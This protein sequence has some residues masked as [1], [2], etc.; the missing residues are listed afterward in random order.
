MNKRIKLAT[1]FY[2]DDYKRFEEDENKAGIANFVF[3]RL[4]ERYLIPLENVPSEFKNGFSLMANACLLI[5]TYESFRQGW[6]DTSH[7]EDRSSERRIPFKSF[8]SREVGFSDFKYES[9]NFY[10]NVRCG[11]LHQG[12]TKGGWKI[13]REKEAPI[14]NKGDK[15]IN[16]TKF[17]K[18][19]RKSLEA[20]RELLITSDWDDEVWDNCRKKISYV[21]QNCE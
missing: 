16:A 12:E 8:F 21:I 19:L 10:S 15:T 9:Y 6:E 14:F 5:E 18:E 1:D 11:I 20:Y 2:I 3:K 13:T 7:N 4:S 17:F